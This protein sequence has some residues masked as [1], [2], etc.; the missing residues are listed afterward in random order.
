MP[1]QRMGGECGW[2]KNNKGTDS[3]GGKMGTKTWIKWQGTDRNAT[4]C[5]ARALL[6]VQHA[7]LGMLK[8]ALLILVVRDGLWVGVR[9]IS[10]S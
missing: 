8:R 7:A 5:G 2:S 4:L 6:V 9:K 3:K 10:K 1:E